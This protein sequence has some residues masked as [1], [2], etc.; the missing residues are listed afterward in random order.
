M[1]PLLKDRIIL[2]L[3]A[4]GTG[5]GSYA[6]KISKRFGIPEYSTGQH[7]RDILNKPTETENKLL[8]NKISEVFKIQD[9]HKHLTDLLSKGKLIP[10]DMLNNIIHFRFLE[11]KK[12]ESN[13]IILDGYPRTYE[14]AESFER[15]FQRKID[16]VININQKESIIVK[17]LMGR[18][19]CSKCPG[20]FN[21]AD[22]DEDGYLMPSIK[23]K[24]DGK[25]DYCSSDLTSRA[26]DTIEV[27]T[28]RLQTYNKSSSKMIEFY[29]QQGVLRSFE[30]K[31]GFDDIGLLYESVERELI[32]PLESKNYH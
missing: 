9:P 7:L 2:M 22:I 27:I 4:P 17:K 13:S 21:L 16:L 26:D 6:K 3:G 23:P 19:A 32:T 10:M 12:T 8:L 30:M 24:V 11:L 29:N 28:E 25:C 20:S 5:K 14:Q 1:K 15:N 31:R 18:R